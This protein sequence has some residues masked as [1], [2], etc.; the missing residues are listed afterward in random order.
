LAWS[1]REP[2]G[3]AGTTVKSVRYGH[4]LA[5]LDEP[6]RLG[7]GYKQYEV[8]HLVRLPQITRLTELRVPLS[9]IESIGSTDDDL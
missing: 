2:A 9:Q 8:R 7:N 6:E 1:T 3:L 4:Q 5:L